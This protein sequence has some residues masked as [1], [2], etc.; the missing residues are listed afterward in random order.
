MKDPYLKGAQGIAIIAVVCGHVLRTIGDAGFLQDGRAAYLL[1]TIKYS[2]SSFDFPLLFFIFGLQVT[3]SLKRSRPDFLRATLYTLAYPYLLWSLLQMLVQWAVAQ[4]E[5]HPFALS[6]LARV[7]WAPVGQFW[8]LYALCICQ[9]VAYLTIRTD[10]D[11]G[12]GTATRV[13]RMLFAAFAIVCAVLAIATTWGIVT[14]TLW[15][16]MFYLFGMLLARRLHAWIER[17]T[18]PFAILGAGFV[19]VA[20]LAVGR[21]FGG[22]RDVYALPASFAGIAMA[23]L[24]AQWLAKRRGAHWLTSLGAAWKPIYLLHVLATAAVWI[25]LLR[26]NIVQPIVH[27]VLGTAVGIALPLFLYLLS[28]RLR[29]VRLAGFSQVSASMPHKTI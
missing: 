16:L 1:T 29:V 28:K 7:A 3:A 18:T 17:F 4:Y 25:M 13:S 14:M 22:Y 24:S 8:F 23:L 9:L 26:L 21:H 19:F 12:K 20:A 10:I 15:G 6:E 5:N 2:A 11:N 27:A